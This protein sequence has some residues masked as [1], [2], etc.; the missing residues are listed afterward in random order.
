M[1]RI[2][3]TG[4]SGFLGKAI[5]RRLVERGDEVVTLARHGSSMLAALG[6]D[7]RL[8]DIADRDAVLAAA[9]N[10]D[11]VIHT[12]AKAGVWGD[13]AAYRAAN[14]DGTAHVIHACR[15]QRVRA[16][17]H[18]SSPSVVFDGSDQEGL[19]ESAPYPS[20][21]LAA[22][23]ETKAEAERVVLKADG[24]AQLRTL[25]LRPHLMWGPGDPHLVP[26]VLALAD[27][28][29]LMLIGK[30]GKLVDAVYVDNAAAAHVAALDR[31]LASPDDVAGRAYFIT[32]HEPWPMEQ[33]LTRIA[34]AG[35]RPP[36]RRR[37]AAPV[38]Y[39]AGWLLERV[40]T[41]RPAS[42]EPRL[43]RFVAKQLATA[44]WYDNTSAKSR[45]GYIPEVSMDEGFSR[46]AAHLG[47]HGTPP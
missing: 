35:G 14:V 40:H 34:L 41:L 12:A 17:V 16:L 46:L 23:P 27:A 15:T 26:R 2:L 18:T 42:G 43:T 19:D 4:G 20:R 9:T 32:N 33:I 44:H 8:G 28:G 39:A 3:V 30:S 25:A 36:P 37:V 11:A 21:F 31:L 13:P 29:R 22:Y 47:R 6:V 24:V 1:T 5:V 10:A 45:L 38:A 7:Q